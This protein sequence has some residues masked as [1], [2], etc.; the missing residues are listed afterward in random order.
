[1][2]WYLSV[3][4]RE[5]LTVSV[6]MGT[7]NGAKYL[8]E[9]LD[10]LARQTRVPLDLVVCDDDSADE[11]TEVIEH[12][13]ATAP[14]QVRLVRNLERLGFAENFMQAARLCR[15]DLIA[16]CD[17]DDV[18]MPEKLD[19]CVAEFE[20]DADVVVVV[21]SRQ[22]GDRQRH[23]RPVLR[24]GPH[25]G[26]RSFERRRQV[27]TPRTL[28]LL[29]WGVPGFAMVF[30]RRVIEAAD[31]LGVPIPE[32]FGA[33]PDHDNWTMFVAGAL[34]K[35]V[36]IPDVLVYY[37]QH[38]TNV[39]G[40]P[41]SSTLRD[42]L[43]VEKRDADATAQALDREACRASGRVELL[44]RI[45]GQGANP[46]RS[47]IWR[48]RAEASRRRAVWYRERA[49][50][51]PIV[52]NALRGDYRPQVRGGQGAKSLAR[53]VTKASTRYRSRGLL[54]R[55][56]LTASRRDRHQASTAP[57]S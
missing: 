22:I 2:D 10:S 30:E 14:F 9:Q 18:W 23:G 32:S 11:T 6:A 38:E 26:E 37:R 12:F 25:H 54:D 28:P 31:F 46:A 42:A 5:E 3:M 47:A 17:Q 57:D 40:A 49:S 27:R 34:G 20:R 39:Y 33:P 50:L 16:W 44:E 1:M 29:E 43:R 36:F 53:D 4:G 55:F 8:Q 21:H 7:Y 35:T 24:G 15:G 56:S 41:A 45:V 19:R 13:A 48:R 51:V 52:R